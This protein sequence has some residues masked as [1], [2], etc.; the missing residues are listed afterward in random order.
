MH[1]SQ[2]LIWERMVFQSRPFWSFAT[3]KFKSHFPHVKGVSEEEFY[4]CVNRVQPDLIRV[5]ADGREGGREGGRG[6]ISG[7]ALKI[8]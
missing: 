6:W 7:L 8:H 1:E 5:E 4:R 3:G 2:S